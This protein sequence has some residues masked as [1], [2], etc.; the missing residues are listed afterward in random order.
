MDNSRKLEGKEY[1]YMHHTVYRVLN[2]CVKRI[3]NYEF[4]P[5]AQSFYVH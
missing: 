3:R 1:I 5:H 2:A 4:L